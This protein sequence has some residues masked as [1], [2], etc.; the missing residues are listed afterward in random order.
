MELVG[1]LVGLKFNPHTFFL[2]INSTKNYELFF[3]SHSRKQEI[4]LGGCTA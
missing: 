1:W 4:L 3:L 2:A